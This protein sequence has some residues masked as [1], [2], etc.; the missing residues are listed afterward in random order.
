MRAPGSGLESFNASPKEN[1]NPAAE[2]PVVRRHDTRVPGETLRDAGL[3][4]GR[5]A[6]PRL[7]DAGLRRA[8]GDGLLRA[9]VEPVIRRRGDRRAD[10]RADPVDPPF[11]PEV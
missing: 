1:K 10:Q 7:L 11:A 8:D 4:R 2:R 6:R 9:Q 3:A 5:V